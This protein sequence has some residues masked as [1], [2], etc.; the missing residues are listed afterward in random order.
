MDPLKTNKQTPRKTEAHKA[1]AQPNFYFLIISEPHSHVLS[2]AFQTTDDPSWQQSLKTLRAHTQITL[3]PSISPIHSSKKEEAKPLFPPKPITPRCVVPA[4]Q[5]LVALYWVITKTGGLKIF[6]SLLNQTQIFLLV[7]YSPSPPTLPTQPAELCPGMFT[8]EVPRVCTQCQV[9]SSSCPA[10]GHGDFLGTCSEL[11]GR[12]K[13]QN[14]QG[15]S[16]VPAKVWKELNLSTSHPLVTQGQVQTT[17]L[18]KH[19]DFLGIRDER[20]VPE[21]ALINRTGW[22]KK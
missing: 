20:H 15:K 22:E 17:G 3:D 12:H 10:Q 18:G 2:P 21:S 13:T 9:G 14:F 4:P 1:W 19:S 7:T 5:Y 6:F 8:G 16:W 11:W